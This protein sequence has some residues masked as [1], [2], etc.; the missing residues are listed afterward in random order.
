MLC[1]GAVDPAPLISERVGLADAP[2]ALER[3][4]RPEQLVGVFVQPWR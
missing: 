4:R 1:S 2:S 3:L